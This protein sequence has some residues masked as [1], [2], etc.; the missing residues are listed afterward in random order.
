[1]KF[2]LFFAFQLPRPWREGDEARLFRE[3]MEQ[4]ELADR[5]GIEYCWGQ[6]HDFLEEYCHSSA[7]E[8]YLAAFSQRT[9]RIRIGHGIVH[10]P[11]RFNHPVRVAERIATLDLVSGGRVEWGTGEAG[12]RIEL[13]AF[14]VPYVDKRAMWEEAVRECAR[15]MCAEPYPGYQGTSFSM[16][17]RNVVPKPI[18]KPH[19]PLWMAC[20]N[21]A[22]LRIAARHGIG[23]LNFAFM[24]ASEARFWVREYYETFRRKC[25]PLGLAVNPQVAMLT[26]FMCHRDSQMARERGLEGARFFA[27]GL[28]HYYR[29]GTHV[30]GRTNLWSE[31]KASPSFAMAGNLG[32]GTPEEIRG[33]FEAFE[34]AGVDQLILL[35]QAGNYQHEQI[36]E[37]LELFC[38]EVLPEFKKRDEVAA[39]RKRDLLAPFVDKAISRVAPMEIPDMLP[40]VA[41]YAEAVKNVGIDAASIQQDRAPLA[42]SLWRLQ[43]GGPMKRIRPSAK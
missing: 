21:R 24:N 16:P 27:Y 9:K 30:P 7:P 18:Q 40:S 29:T 20:A 13:E 25:V 19:P 15:M 34:K 32:V 4:V 41:C 6:E 23:A 35:Q 31:F 5:L 12:T 37:S 2:A 26:Q 22:S 3:G 14:G 36:C 11:P 28:S 10:M 38:R 43:V 8:V 17:P 42:A 39:R 1:M 33:H